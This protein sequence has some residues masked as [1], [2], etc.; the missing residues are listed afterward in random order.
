MYIYQ[1]KEWPSFTWNHETLLFQLG[2]VRHLQGRLLGKMLALG[3]DLQ[4]EA[5][6][7]TQ[8][9]N[10]L[11]SSEIEGEF[12]DPGQVR[13]SIAR[14]LGIGTS[15]LVPSG[16]EVDGVVEMML[17]ATQR[18]GIPLTKDR[19][20]GWH[21]ALFPTGRSGMYRIEVGQWR[22]DARGPMQVVSGP[23]GRERVHFQAPEAGVVDQEMAVFL[24]WFNREEAMDP[25]LKAAVAHLWLVTIHPF[26]DGNGRIA[27]AVADLQLSRADGSALRFYSM[28]AQIRQERKRYYEMLEETQR[29]GLDITAWLL[30]FLECLERAL[31]AT[32]QNLAR[33]LAKARFW[34][35]HHHTPL[36]HRQRLMINRLLDGFT[37]KLTSSRWGKIAKCSPDTALRDI[38]D[39]VEKGILRKGPEGG[40]STGYE[41]IFS[42]PG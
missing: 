7:E 22:T 25:V 6:L 32:A 3:F 20:F 2:K 18:Y 28:S 31:E 4:Q 1:R 16:R 35:Q 21:A 11:K 41:I 14:R 8:T 39:L 40:R 9:L 10:V 42:E 26:E 24:N 23:M 19:L 12:L 5:G 37:G 27:R 38:Q 34:E 33:I 17:D 30:W 15:E 29:G 36:N 13:S